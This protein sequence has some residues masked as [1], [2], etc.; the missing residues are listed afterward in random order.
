M[1][2]DVIS[3]ETCREYILLGNIH[4]VVDKYCT[5]Q[6]CSLINISAEAGWWPRLNEMG[7]NYTIRSC[8]RRLHKDSFDFQMQ[9]CKSRKSKVLTFPPQTRR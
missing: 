6:W 9:N 2:R 8:S 7:T 1:S 3:D 4:N 5:K